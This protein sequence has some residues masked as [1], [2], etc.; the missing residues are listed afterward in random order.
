MNGPRDSQIVDDEDDFPT[1]EFASEDD[2]EDEALV[3][4]IP[5][6]DSEELPG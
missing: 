5:D 2:P 4:V 3:E 1:D 6:E